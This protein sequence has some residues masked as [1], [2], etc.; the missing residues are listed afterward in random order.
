[1]LRL[2]LG[3]VLDEVWFGVWGVLNG[4]SFISRILVLSIVELDWCSFVSGIWSIYKC[5]NTRYHALTMQQHSFD[6]Q[7]QHFYL[8]ILCP[9]SSSSTTSTF[10]R[11]SGCRNIN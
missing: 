2:L 9:I 4:V 6:M 7:T 11:L 3:L 5:P 10:L 1:M 8:P